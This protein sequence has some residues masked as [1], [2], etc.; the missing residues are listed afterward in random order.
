L[1]TV[2][3]SSLPLTRWHLRSQIAQA[4]SNEKAT[5]TRYTALILVTGALLAPQVRAETARDQTLSP[6]P[7]PTEPARVDTA[8]DQDPAPTEAPTEAA[9]PLTLEQAQQTA[10]ERN[11]TI[12]ATQYELDRAEALLRQ[13]WAGLLPNL[14]ASFQHVMADEP[15]VVNFDMFG[16]SDLFGGG[17]EIVVRQQHNTQLGLSA[18]QP[19]FNGPMY[20]RIRM[21]RLSRRL[22]ELTVEQVRHQMALGVAQAFYGA[23]SA[24]RTLGLVERI[25]QLAEEDVAAA[26]ARLAAQAGLA[27]DVAR[28]ELQLQTTRTQEQSTRLALENA[29]DGLALL[30]GI[31]P[32]ELP[33]LADPPRPTEALAG[34]EEMLDEAQQRRLDLRQAEEQVKLARLNLRSTW[35]GFAPTLDLNWGLTHI[36]TDLGGFGDR[37][38]SWN[39]AIVASLPLFDGGY[40]YGQLREQRAQLAQAELNLESLRQ[41]V[42]VQIRQAFRA[43]QTALHTVAISQRQLELARDAYRLARASY[44]AGAASN[45]EVVDAQRTLAQAEVDVEL[46]RLNGQLSLVELISRLDVGPGAGGTRAPRGGADSAPASAGPSSSAAAPTMG[47]MPGGMR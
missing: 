9:P 42:R 20:P 7:A 6:S 14:G 4:S 22:S 41:S 29:R 30:M 16:S 28:A 27:I 12:R 24:Q 15:T 33:P 32:D 2:N 26:R 45:L 25:L 36:L 31:D 13:A 10:L 3:L 19:L 18:R 8:T 39:L 1:V 35:L 23:L 17:Q 5:M 37:R 43:W 46:Q 21:A 47:G 34:M 11:P 40:R 44:A 38:T